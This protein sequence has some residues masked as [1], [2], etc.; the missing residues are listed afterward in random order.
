MAKT[1]DEA[2]LHRVARTYFTA[3]KYVLGAKTFTKPR[4]CKCSP[5]H[6]PLQWNMF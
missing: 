3:V 1:L 2:M 5:E 6:I 4:F